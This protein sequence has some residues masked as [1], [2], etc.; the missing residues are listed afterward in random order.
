MTFC[1]ACFPALG[2]SKCEQCICAPSDICT[3]NTHEPITFESLPDDIIQLIFDWLKKM[4]MDETFSEVASAYSRF[5]RSK[6]RDWERQLKLFC[7]VQKAGVLAYDRRYVARLKK[8]MKKDFDP[9]RCRNCFSHNC[10]S[11]NF[12][13]DCHRCW[14]I[15]LNEDSEEREYFECDVL[16]LF[17]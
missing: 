8:N 2:S 16:E 10:F 1:D 9:V 14:E 4:V 3:L 15:Q 7:S 5:E 13:R 11:L 17:Q 12:F 6:R